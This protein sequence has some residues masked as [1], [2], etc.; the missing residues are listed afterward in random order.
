MDN[1][2][3]DEKQLIKETY[4]ATLQPERLGEF[5][6]FWEAYIDNKI[7]SENGK[8]VVESVIHSHFSMALGIVEKIRHDQNAENYIQKLVDEHHGIGMIVDI[9]GQILASNVDAKNFTKSQIHLAETSI[10]A[11]DIRDLQSWMRNRETEDNPYLFKQVS[12]VNSEDRICLFVTPINHDAADIGTT[13][14]LYIITT[15]DFDISSESLPS[16]R[17]M[18]K[19]S[20]AEGEIAMLLANGKS[21]TEISEKRQT[22]VYTV[23]TQIKRIL[24]KTESRDISDLVRKVLS[25]SARFNSVLSQTRLIS[26]SK[27]E[28]SLTRRY[29]FILPDG[30]FMEYVEQGHPNGYPVLQ[31]HSVTNGVVLTDSAAQK[32]V[33]GNWRFITPSRPGYGNS[34]PNPTKSP[35]DNINE[36]VEDF[37]CL[38]RHLNIDK[39]LIL[40]GWAGCFSHHFAVRFPE[41]VQGI[42]QTG[43]VP[44]WHAEHLN[45]MKSRH[46]IILK[47]S[48]YAPAAV[49]YMVRVAKALIDS[50]RG[51]FFVEGTESENAVDISALH[52]DRHLF[53]VITDGH[54]HNLQQGTQAFIA[55]LKTIHTDWSE[56]CKKIN[57]P[58][59][60][61]RGS[62]NHDQPES[63]F[64]KYQNEVQQANIK[65]VEGAG[66]FMY[67]THFNR[68]LEEFKLLRSGICDQNHKV[69]PLI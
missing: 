46:R 43:S 50:G 44:I 37:E 54:K 55:D 60:V 64:K 24:S 56:V 52:R 11:S 48:L 36:A 10:E 9:E 12:I 2:A 4:A 63:A 25:L 61:L 66:V 3:Y 67:L 14:H 5:E 22:K 15:V 26:Q 59:T 13:P 57:V 17:D 27:I 18:Y 38:L 19:L 20:Q 7:L 42:L 47:T 65:T 62:E 30:R 1:S 40:S 28:N 69:L 21:V 51:H 58:V 29:S 6:N 33:L 45:Y 16:I 31:W 34:D 53:N 23:R 39:C 49:P 32:A 8:K 35:Q 68:V 41:R